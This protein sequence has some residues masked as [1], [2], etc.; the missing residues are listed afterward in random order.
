[1]F[2]IPLC[3]IAN[4]LGIFRKAGL[5]KFT[6]DYM[7]SIIM[8]EDFQTLAYIMSISMTQKGFFLNMPIL[9]MAIL[10]LSFEFK[11]IL[12]KNPNSPIISIA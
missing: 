2:S 11:N 10:T 5:P 1:M 12:D 6:V 4:I 3:V 8:C 9:I 7:Q